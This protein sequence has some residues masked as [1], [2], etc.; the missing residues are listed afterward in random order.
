MRH[1]DALHCSPLG[2]LQD[3]LAALTTEGQVL[4]NHGD[5]ISERRLRAA[6]ASL[7]RG[8]GLQVRQATGQAGRASH[9]RRG[10]LRPIY[11][12]C[13]PRRRRAV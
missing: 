9:A 6:M 3:L 8:L 12:D 1:L 5:D 11:S 10:R 7:S 13:A 2:L 4:V